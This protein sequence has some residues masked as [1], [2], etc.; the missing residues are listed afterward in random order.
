M[1]GAKGKAWMALCAVVIL[2]VGYFVVAKFAEDRARPID[3]GV[4]QPNTTQ[5]ADQWSELAA[6]NTLITDPTSQLSA[7]QITFLREAATRTWT[8][9]SGPGLDPTTHLP[10]DDVPI[11]GS[12]SPT[13][14]LKPPSTAQ[15][16]TNPVLIG[17][18]L[19]SITAARDLGLVTD[20]QALADATAVLH[21]I[22]KLAKYDGF[23]SRWYNTDTGAAITG[24]RG[25]AI[26]KLYVSTVDNGW[27]AQGLLI[28]EQ[29]FPQLSS[30]F[31]SLLSAMQW[32]LLYEPTKNILYNGYQV[33]KGPSQSSYEN[34]YSGPRIA[35][36]MAI[37]SGQVPGSLW[38]G[39]HRS[40]PL[41]NHQRQVPQGPTTTYTDPQTHQPYKVFEGHYVY[42]EIKFVPTMTGSAFQAL[43]PNMVIPE[44]TMA[45]NNL[46]LNDRNTALAISA[47]GSAISSPITGWAPTTVPGP[48]T[49]Y[50]NY[51]VPD[52][53]SDPGSVDTSVVTPSAAFLTLPVIPKQ[54]YTNI[55]ELVQKYPSIYT[56]DGFLDSV[57][58]QNGQIAGRY[59]TVDQMTIL[60]S[61]DNA[62]DHDQLQSYVGKSTYAQTL[63]PYMALEQYSIMGLDK[64]V[65]TPGAT[66]A[67]PAPAV[68][69]SPLATTRPRRRTRTPKPKALHFRL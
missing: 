37:G 61:I 19:S 39:P 9:L 38:W 34:T 3:A 20:A 25:A 48:T 5:S 62:L 26:T 18:Y 54:A 23:L 42:D 49:K 12:A 16:F 63:A 40:P 21:E 68:A 29:S 36:D 31:A 52:L 35:Y 22:Q 66:G 7:G 14:T 17:L 8:F 24:P 15:D 11:K 27:L 69:N 50:A 58:L 47:Y 2:G 33:G 64:S 60:L 1:F 45:P 43:G 65:P 32:K 4:T 6:T 10:V 55:Q 51:G 56:Q 46:G 44:V 59:L 30:G 28:A 53:A 57:N 13:V 67:A 41:R